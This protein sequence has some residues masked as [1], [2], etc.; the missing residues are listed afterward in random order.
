V[1]ADPP[2]LYHG[3][4]RPFD[5]GGLLLPRAAHNGKPTS[6]PMAAG[7]TRPAAADQWV[8][9]TTERALAWVY[10][11]HAA[12]RGRPR[13]LTVSPL[14]DVYYDPEHSRDMAAY[15]CTAALVLAVSL[16]P[17]VSE[18]DARAGWVDA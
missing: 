9:V 2:P 10:A 13:V 16:D 15:R 8:Y 3:T 12:G 18:A 5:K 4:R 6:A 17:E 7:N 11:W 1:S 14:S